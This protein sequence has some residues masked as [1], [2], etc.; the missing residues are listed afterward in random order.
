MVLVYDI[1]GFI[2]DCSDPSLLDM[3]LQ[4]SCNQ[5]DV[6]MNIIYAYEKFNSEKNRAFKMSSICIGLFVLMYA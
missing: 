5:Y 6:V 4:L 1:D 3:G 2:H